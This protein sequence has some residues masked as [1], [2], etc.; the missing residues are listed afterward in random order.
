MLGDH[1][2][3]V[4]NRQYRNKCKFCDYSHDRKLIVERHEI[5]CKNNPVKKVEAATVGTLPVSPE[6]MEVTKLLDAEI[7]KAEEKERA[8]GGRLEEGE[9]PMGDYDEQEEGEITSWKSPPSPAPSESSMASFRSVDG[10]PY[11]C[12]ECDKFLKV[13][14]S[15]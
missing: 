14:I 11:K 15:W 3:I 5:T 9:V 8:M 4:H 1:Q 2:R 7:E 6:K 12:P 10:P 13:S